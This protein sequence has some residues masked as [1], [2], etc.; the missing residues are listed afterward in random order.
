GPTSPWRGLDA[1]VF[2]VGLVG[3]SLLPYPPPTAVARVTT[4][5]RRATAVRGRRCF[6]NPPWR[7]RRPRL[8]L[9][10]QQR[11]RLPL[12]RRSPTRRPPLPAQP[13]PLQKPPPLRESLRRLRK[14]AQEEEEDIYC[15]RC[16]CEE[17]EEQANSG[18][19]GEFQ[20]SPGDRGVPSQG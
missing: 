4:A 19:A 18:Q 5:C 3:L 15:L 16:R 20:E 8:V 9:R 7:P 2:V 11:S 14:R 13:P 10:L 6:R 1:A 17:E 12:A